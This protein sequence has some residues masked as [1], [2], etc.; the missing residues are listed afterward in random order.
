VAESPFIAA[1]G[2]VE[3]VS[4]EV[5]IASQLPGRLA[6]VP[7]EEGDRVR[8]GQ[9]LAVLV[10]EDYRARVEF[11]EAQLRLKEAELRRVV[12]GARQQERL[13][14]AAQVNAAKAV[15]DNAR[16]EMERRRG[17]HRSGD[18]SRAEA[19]RAGREWQVAQARYDAAV[20]RSSFVS[21]EAREDERERAEAD[22]AAAG[23]QAREARAM[24][25]KTFIRSPLTGVVLR[26]HRR[27]GE[28]V[29]DSFDTPIVAVAD[30]SRLRVRADVD[31]TD[32]AKVRAGQRAYVT[33]DAFGDRKFWGRV[34][35][36]GQVLG[37]KN[38]RTGEPTERVD[39]KILET[40]IDLED[41]GLPAG[42]RVN[43]YLLVNES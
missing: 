20:Q 15:L 23:A 37:R 38:V 33:A 8:R 31:E 16:A 29:S 11:A 12:N 4:E 30:S 42:L 27:A 25:E 2:R 40:L 39:T 35:R 14:A 34:A 43:A 3:P 17:L 9:V 1:A 36:V 18:L 13:E 5:T 41:A 7:V 10:N 21:A 24:L 32:I 19:E 26:K 28:S 6:A 22:V